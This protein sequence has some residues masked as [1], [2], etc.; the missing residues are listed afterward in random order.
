MDILI[1]IGIILL[2]V[3]NAKK[4]KQK[5]EE[6]RRRA[7]AARAAQPSGQAEPAA[8]D[9]RFPWDREP[10]TPT[11]DPRFPPVTPVQASR[12]PLDPRFPDIDAAELARNQGAAA[13]QRARQQAQAAAVSKQQPAPAPR[14]QQTVMQA[15]GESISQQVGDRMQTPVGRRHVLEASSVT[16]HAHTES[17]IDNGR[18]EACPPAV[19]RQRQPQQEAAPRMQ[20][21]ALH[22]AFDQSSVVSGLLYSEILGKP[23]A[24]RR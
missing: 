20:V 8:A 14:A 16:G 13:Q 6:A 19:L 12:P 1:L 22:L 3:S 21:G 2:V 18:E 15:V 17:S 7:Q 4:K 23:K 5:E 10:S 9:A 24:L 11:A